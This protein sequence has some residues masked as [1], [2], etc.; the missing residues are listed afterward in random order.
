M[1]DRAPDGKQLRPDNSVGRLFAD[2]RS[3]LP[4]YLDFVDKV[5]V[6]EH[7][8]PTLATATAAL[9]YLPALLPVA[10]KITATVQES[11]LI[12]RDNPAPARFSIPVANVRLEG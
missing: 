2:P 5:W 8:E 7:A 12:E 3:M 9:P 4:L 11:K 1:A 6:P 10:F